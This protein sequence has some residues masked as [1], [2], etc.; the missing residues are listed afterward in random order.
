METFVAVLAIVLGIVGII[1]SVAPALPGPPISW[2]GLLVLYIWGFELLLSSFL[3]LDKAVV[4]SK[5]SEFSL[6]LFLLSDFC[7]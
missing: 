2:V 7:I 1:G 5:F 4:R 3:K 6:D